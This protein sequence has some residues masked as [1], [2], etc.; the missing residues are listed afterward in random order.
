MFFKFLF[1]RSISFFGIVLLF[2]ILIVISIL[3]RVKMPSG[4]IIFKQKRIGQHGKLFTMYKFRSM[5]VNHS[6][7]SISVKGE[8][9]I[10]P[11]GAKLRKYKLD[12]LP[13]LWNVLIGDMSF[14][15][16]RPDVPGYADKLEGEDRRI[17]LLK[18]GITG[19]ASL[20]YRNEEELLAQ[21]EDPQKYND[22]V[23]FPNKVRINIEYLD[24]WSFWND[25]KIIIYTLL[26]KDL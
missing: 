6:G 24:H 2:P 25:I 7:S 3:I 9:R 17:L 1:D 16:P 11:L 15:G 14:V 8:S 4:S 26:G 20:K 22:E 10:T 12:E 5:T 13:E 21:Q 19:P 23:L 18:P